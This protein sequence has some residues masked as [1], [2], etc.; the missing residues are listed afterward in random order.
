[1][2]LLLLLLL[3][4]LPQFLIPF[5]VASYPAGSHPTPGYPLADVHVLQLL[6]VVGRGLVSTDSKEEHQVEEEEHEVLSH[7]GWGGVVCVPFA[8]SSC[9]AD[10]LGEHMGGGV[11]VG[12]SMR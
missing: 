9:P 11:C 6:D 12:E 4:L 1:M 7:L 10:Q 8:P 2:L 5:V 3:L